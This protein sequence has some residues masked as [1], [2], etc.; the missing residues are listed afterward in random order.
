MVSVN[1]LIADLTAI[2]RDRCREKVSA[3][4]HRATLVDAEPV[5]SFFAPKG[6]DFG[7][8][9]RETLQLERGLDALGMRRVLAIM[10]PF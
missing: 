3:Q 7:K 9:R 2:C 5:C 8:A 10:V 1:F 6:L 4:T